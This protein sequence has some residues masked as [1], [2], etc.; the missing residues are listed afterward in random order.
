MRSGSPTSLS[1]QAGHL[2]LAVQDCVRSAFDMSTEGDLAASLGNLL[3]CLITLI[4]KKCLLMFRW[5]FM[6]FNSCQVPPVLSVGA[7]ENSQA[8]SCSFTPVMYLYTLVRSPLSRLLSRLKSP[9]PFSLFSYEDT[10][11]P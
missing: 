8:P 10:P 9:R 4:V 11:F 2:E 5:N 6:C 3:Q 7:K 1:A